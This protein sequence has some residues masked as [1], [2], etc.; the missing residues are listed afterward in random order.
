MARSRTTTTKGKRVKLT[1][2]EIEIAAVV[3]IYCFPL[4]HAASNRPAHT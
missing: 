1:A 2:E 4:A 3:P